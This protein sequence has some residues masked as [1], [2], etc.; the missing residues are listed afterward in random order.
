MDWPT[1]I[2]TLKDIMAKENI[3]AG[4]LAKMLGV[5]VSSVH[6]YLSMRQR[7]SIMTREKLESFV[8]EHQATAKQTN[9]QPAKKTTAKRGAKKTAA[10]NESKNEDAKEAKQSK[11]TRKPRQTKQAAKKQSNQQAA[12]KQENAKQTAKKQNNKRTDKTAAKAKPEVKPNTKPATKA[13]TKSAKPADQQSSVKQAAPKA[14]AQAKT[15]AQSASKP[16]RNQPATQQNAKP[17]QDNKQTPQ[18]T[19]QNTPIA[20]RSKT[21]A[22]RQTTGSAVRIYVDESFGQG[23]EKPFTVGMVLCSTTP[24]IMPFK[25]FTSTLYPFGWAP[26][27][28]VKA[29][30]KDL[31]NVKYVLEG[32]VNDDIK[33]VA[34]R[35]K[36]VPPLLSITDDD[37]TMVSIFPYVSALITAI[38]RAQ[39]QGLSGS[40]YQ[41]VIDRTNKLPAESLRIVQNLLDVYFRLAASTPMSF[42]VT[43]G[44][45]R[46]Q[47]GLQLADFVSHYAYVQ[48]P[49]QAADFAPVTTVIDDELA[50]ARRFAYYSGLRVVQ[51]RSGA[52]TIVAPETPTYT[53]A[54]ADDDATQ[55]SDDVHSENIGRAMELALAFKDAIG[56]TATAGLSGKQLEA[57]RSRLKG[58]STTIVNW[59]DDSQAKLLNGLANRSVADFRERLAIITRIDKPFK[60]SQEIGEQQFRI[61]E[62]QLDRILALLDSYSTT[63]E[64]N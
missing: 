51:L 6:N 38:E 25:E 33:M 3:T 58:L 47:K 42:H 11:N 44:D 20:S 14:S 18:T 19:T 45:S 16:V 13:E 7:A 23:S 21:P 56:K 57:V 32:S 62:T 9:K 39:K 12:P 55:L 30:G 49:E 52:Q 4:E 36:M 27:D 41:I 10:A 60:S 43:D 54:G 64:Q 22:R 2:N 8:A 15:T 31:S 50:N 46:A 1:L 53:E 29:Q 61:F 26:G 48:T 5:S 63:A 37:S 34:F 59:L 24:G 28:E 35:T 17:Q 40:Q